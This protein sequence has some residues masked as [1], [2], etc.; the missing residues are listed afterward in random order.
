MLLQ[1]FFFFF[2]WRW[3]QKGIHNN[4]SYRIQVAPHSLLNL[5]SLS[6]TTQLPP[7]FVT[8]KWQSLDIN[9]ARNWTHENITVCTCALLPLV[10]Q[11]HVLKFWAVPAT[12]CY[13]GSGTLITWLW[14][15]GLELLLDASNW[16]KRKG[17]VCIGNM[18]NYTARW[19]TKCE[20]WPCCKK[21]LICSPR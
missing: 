4:F 3:K 1:N 20:R 6:H 17:Q 11:V 13:F 16:K 14:L 8:A 5:I 21:Q 18:Y 9:W 15:A 7:R 2:K 19:P 12:F 10:L